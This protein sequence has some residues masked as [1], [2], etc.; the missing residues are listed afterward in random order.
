[1]TEFDVPV[2]WSCHSEQLFLRSPWRLSVPIPD[3]M[4]VCV[5][6]Q[7]GSKSHLCDS[8]E[9]DSHTVVGSGLLCNRAQKSAPQT[10]RTATAVQMAKPSTVVTVLLLRLGPP[11]VCTAGPDLQTRKWPVTMK[12]VR[13]SRRAA[14]CTHR[15]SS[16]CTTPVGPSWCRWCWGSS[17]RRRSWPQ[18]YVCMYVCVLHIYIYI[19]THIRVYIYIYTCIYIY[20]YRERERERFIIIIIIAQVIINIIIIIITILILLQSGQVQC[21]TPSCNVD[22]QECGAACVRVAVR[23]TIARSKGSMLGSR[24]ASRLHR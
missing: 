9:R 16:S 3:M 1:M 5:G 2:W 21:V 8:G 24:S 18:Y 22:L 6:Q 7:L 23:L 17:T 12:T 19:C 11:A 15:S 13:R 10:Q 4:D 20:I 14:S